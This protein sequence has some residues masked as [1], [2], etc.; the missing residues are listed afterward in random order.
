MEE[1]ETRE[2][3]EDLVRQYRWCKC[4]CDPAQFQ[5]RDHYYLQ[6]DTQESRW[7]MPS[8]PY[9]LWDAEKQ[10]LDPAGLQQLAEAAASPAPGQP[11]P[12]YYGYNPKIHGAYDPNAPYAQYHKQKREQEAH[13]DQ[14]SAGQIPSS[15]GAYSMAGSFN[16]FTGSFQG[17][18]KSAERHNDFNKSGRQMGAYFDVD[19]AA[20]AHEGRSLKEERRNEKLSKKQ[21]KELADKRRAKKEKKRMDFYKS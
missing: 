3:H 6:M 20:N 1:G 5:G 4:V 19:A 15:D 18:D 7:E 8:E 17:A 13:A 2:T 16:R 11:D 10:G 14:I 12:D 21:I 9:W